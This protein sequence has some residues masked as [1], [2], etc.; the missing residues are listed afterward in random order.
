M[1]HL[2][3]RMLKHERL[4][5]DMEKRVPK[6]E[7]YTLELE[8]RVLGHEHCSLDHERTM[9]QIKVE[10]FKVHDRKLHSDVSGGMKK[11]EELQ[12]SISIPIGQ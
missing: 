8:W 11:K 12:N 5:L 6:H 10:C 4:L 1:L 9:R 7:H 2:E 3:Q